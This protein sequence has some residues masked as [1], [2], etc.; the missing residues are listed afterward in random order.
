M[1]KE[2]LTSSGSSLNIPMEFFVCLICLRA[3]LGVGFHGTCHGDAA[4]VSGVVACRR[5]LDLRVLR[6]LVVTSSAMPLLSGSFSALLLRYLDTVLF[7]SDVPV[8]FAMVT[9]SSACAQ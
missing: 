2:R 9:I 7:A 3:L 5:L 6:G 1:K 8:T 4:P